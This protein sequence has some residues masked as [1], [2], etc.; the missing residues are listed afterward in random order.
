MKNFRWLVVGVLMLAACGTPPP[1]PPMAAEPAVAPLQSPPVFALIGAR[2]R[3]ELTAEQISVLDS[4]GR[5]NSSANDA[6]VRDA[7]V[8]EM[9]PG[10]PTMDSVA[11]I[12]RQ[13][14]LQ[15]GRGVETLLS[16]EQ[17]R[18][19]CEL[20]RPEG[21]RDGRA[22]PRG[23]QD[24]PRAGAQGRAGRQGMMDDR[25]LSVW[26]WCTDPAIETPPGADPPARE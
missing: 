8:R 23:A 9:R 6:V 14:N 16:D 24:R 17:R 21:R 2:E 1:A 25:S 18:E 5:W 4:I 10:D 12:I 13:N 22:A 26:P 20:F 11:R 7:R 3:L 15:A 19:V